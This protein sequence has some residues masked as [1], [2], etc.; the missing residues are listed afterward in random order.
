MKLKNILLSSLFTICFS[1]ADNPLDDIQHL[2]GYWEI[3]HVEKDN[4]TIK[5]YTY[6]STV[7]FFDVNEKTLKGIRKKVTPTFD[8]TF[9]V[10][11]HESSFMLKIEDNQLNIYYTVN[12]A[13][14]KETIKSIS[15]KKLVITN[16]DG[17]TYIYVPFKSL[18][19][20]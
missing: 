3:Q 20:E 14:Y 5:E 13:T 2:N 12:D 11:E 15:S 1:C 17:L 18:T 7:D 16:Q 10:T 19:F 6:N 9:L 4:K 8:G